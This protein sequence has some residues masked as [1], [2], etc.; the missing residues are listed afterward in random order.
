GASTE[1]SKSKVE[2]SGIIS[3]CNPGSK[4]ATRFPS[5]SNRGVGS[6]AKYKVGG[7][8]GGGT[9]STGVATSC[10]RPCSRGNPDPGGPRIS[11][12]TSKKLSASAGFPGSSVMRPNE[13]R[14]P[15]QLRLGIP[16]PALTVNP[17]PVS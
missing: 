1:P 16:S 2:G 4:I 10:T 5:L 12:L 3:W 7:A 11:K 14:G 13:Q 6:D 15:S 8:P 9:L 17:P